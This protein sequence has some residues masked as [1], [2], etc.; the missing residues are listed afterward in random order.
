MGSTGK[1][2]V[3]FAIGCLFAMLNSISLKA[4]TGDFVQEMSNEIYVRPNDSATALCLG[5]DPCHTLNWYATNR[6]S[7]LIH[8][9]TRMLFIDG[10]HSLNT[11]LN[12]S[13]LYNLSMYGKQELIT[14]SCSTLNATGVWFSKCRN[15]EIKGLTFEGCG[16]RLGAALSFQQGINV[17]LNRVTVKFAVGYGLTISNVFGVISV[18]KCSFSNT[19][20][21]TAQMHNYSAH[22]RIYFGNVCSKNLQFNSLSNISHVHAMSQYIHPSS[23]MDKMS[24]DLK[25]LSIAQMSPL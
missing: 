2:P 19:T 15:V 1:V 10:K 6:K 21:I 5:R 14:I 23:S 20:N 9:D 24:V 22:A 12:V 11:V 4:H 18:D 7:A 3:H 8:S 17:T 25:Y 13:N 16:T